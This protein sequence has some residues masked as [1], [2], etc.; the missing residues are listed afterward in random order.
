MRLGNQNGSTIYSSRG[1]GCQDATEAAHRC[2]APHNVLSC[3]KSELH[4][5]ATSLL[6]KLATPKMWLD[7]QFNHVQPTVVNFLRFLHPQKTCMSKSVED[8]FSF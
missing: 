1:L 6:E 5:A 7:Q 4:G 3:M 8:Y 2:S